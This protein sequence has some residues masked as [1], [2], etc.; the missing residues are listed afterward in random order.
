MKP[1]LE[2]LP[3]QAG[4]SFFMGEFAFPY[5]PTPLHY[6]P[7]YELVLVT[8]SQGQRVVSTHIDSFREG[9][10][11]LL[12]PNLPHLYRNDADYYRPESNLRAGSVVVHF[13]D[14]S[15]GA[16]FLAL[17]QL[18][19]VRYLLSR[20]V[21][22]LDI[23]GQ[24]RTVV[25]DRLHELVRLKGL[26]RLL[27]F[28]DTL[29]LIADS[30][31]CHPITQPS[32]ALP[33]VEPSERL[34]AIL[35]YLTKNLNQSLSLH[36]VAEVAGL[37]RTSLCRYFRERTKRSIWDFRSELRLRFAARQLRETSNSILQ[38]SMDS[39]FNNLSNFNRSF[40]RFYQQTPS[41]Y[42]YK[43]TK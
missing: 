27:R 13:L 33:A 17:P 1:V 10:L 42:R 24:T 16:D 31:E 18:R 9:D 20:S 30:D 3:I 6:H 23:V 21:G 41:Q 39:G 2:H 11:T 15:L 22:G 4:E 37:T 34:N 8:R 40:R 43:L 5:F 12:G 19:A 32:F 7:E 36:E 26:P 25:T 29:R 28:I 38:V 35:D 14:A